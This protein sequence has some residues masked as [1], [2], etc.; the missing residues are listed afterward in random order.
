[1]GN[2]GAVCLSRRDLFTSKILSFS[3]LIL[4]SPAMAAVDCKK[5]C[6]KNCTLVAP[7][8]GK[9]CTDACNEYCAQTDRTDGLSGSVS[10]QNGE[11][12]IFGQGTVPKDGD[13][14]PS[15]KLPWL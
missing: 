1:M 8:D 12:G 7:K 5:D 2:D 6:F 3:F 11:V 9:Y 13:R 15:I 14:P 4:S 10:A